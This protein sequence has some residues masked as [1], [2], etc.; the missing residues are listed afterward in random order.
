MTVKDIREQMDNSQVVDLLFSYLN[1]ISKQLGKISKLL[2][3]QNALTGTT[4][5]NRFTL[6]GGTQPTVIAFNADNT[7]GH[8]N[9]PA[10]SNLL[11]PYQ[12]VQSIY[13]FNEGT[14]NLRYSTNA[15]MN[16]MSAAGLLKPNEARQITINA[17]RIQRLTLAAEG[18][19]VTVRFEV[20]T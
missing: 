1:R 4:W 3:E 11:I 7:E 13:I 12:A 8:Q 5:S 9:L 20:M 6:L 2:E 19:N 15:P 14:G 17:P 18:G 16:Q 10:N